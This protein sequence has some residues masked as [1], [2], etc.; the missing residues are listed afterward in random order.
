MGATACRIRSY[1]DHFPAAGSAH[2]HPQA[3]MV[4]HRRT[5]GIALRITIYGKSG[6]NN[7]DR[8]SAAANRFFKITGLIVSVLRDRLLVFWTGAL[9][10]YRRCGCRVWV[11]VRICESGDESARYAAALAKRNGSRQFAEFFLGRRRSSLSIRCGM[12]SSTHRRAR[13]GDF[14]DVRV[15]VNRR[16][17]LFQTCAGCGRS[18]GSRESLTGRLDG[19][20]ACTGGNSAGV[21][22]FPL[23]R[24]GDR[25]RW[26]GGGAGKATAWSRK[27][28]TDFSAV[29]FL[30]NASLRARHCPGT[31]KGIFHRETCACGLGLRGHW[32][33][34]HQPCA[35]SLFT[36]RRG[37]ASGIRVCAVISDFCRVAGGDIQREGELARRAGLWRRIAW[38]SGVALADRANFYSNGLVEQGISRSG[39]RL[40]GDGVV[41]VASSFARRGYLGKIRHLRKLKNSATIPQLSASKPQLDEQP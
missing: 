24:F 15:G 12:V 26:V 31:F 30:W 34:Y 10:G 20:I 7:A 41:V 13:F 21:S 23:C 37:G 4:H 9:D 29:C 28:S 25:R 38:W 6:R 36:L 14:F 19:A 35:T 27:F 16:G 40:R 2:T 22:I 5:G 33:G 8:L 32:L 1:R 39:D 17:A 11:W 3:S 18:H